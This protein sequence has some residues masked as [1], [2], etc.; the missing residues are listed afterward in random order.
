MLQLEESVNILTKYIYPKKL[1]DSLQYKENDSVS[2]N[3][4]NCYHSVTLPRLLSKH[5]CLQQFSPKGFRVFT[6]CLVHYIILSPWWTPKG[7]FLK[8][9]FPDHW[10]MHSQYFFF[11]PVLW[12]GELVNRL[13]NLSRDFQEKKNAWK[14]WVS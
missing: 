10:K 11:W 2:L 9:R 1:F 13:E 5:F 8:F 12:K 4:I 14:N 3:R 7:K 6:V